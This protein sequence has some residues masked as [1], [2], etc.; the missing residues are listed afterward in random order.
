[1]QPTRQKGAHGFLETGEERSR[2]LSIHQGW[3]VARSASRPNTLLLHTDGA[4]GGPLRHQG[5]PSPGCGPAPLRRLQ[6]RWAVGA[7]RRLAAGDAGCGMRD[8]A[9][10]PRAPRRAGALTGRVVEVQGHLLAAHR[11]AGRVLLEH[12]R[13]VVLSEKGQ[14][15][16]LRSAAGSRVRWAPHLPPSPRPARYAPPHPR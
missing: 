1:M 16:S 6:E 11:D 14:G 7:S 13:G 4:T 5:A 9:G 2:G 8:A 3:V 15:R 12:G 10:T